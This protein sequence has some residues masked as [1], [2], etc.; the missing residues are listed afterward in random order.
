M[1]LLPLEIGGTEGGSLG[2]VLDVRED[3]EREWR[4]KKEGKGK[5][6]SF[7][8]FPLSPSRTSNR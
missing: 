6:G 7:E 3:L 5:V 2:I 1:R 4:E 8:E